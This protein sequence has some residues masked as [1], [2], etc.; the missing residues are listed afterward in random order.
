MIHWGPYSVIGYRK[1]NDYAEW[2][3]YHMYHDGKE[4][5][6]SYFED[7]FG[8]SPPEFGYKDIISIISY[9]I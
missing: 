9:A 2:A 6:N 7:N 5:F 4:V 8:A 1:G 3:P